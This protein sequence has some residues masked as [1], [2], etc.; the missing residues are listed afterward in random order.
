MVKKLKAQT[1][2]DSP[3]MWLVPSKFSGSF[4]WYFFSLI[5]NLLNFGIHNMNT[6]YYDAKKKLFVKFPIYAHIID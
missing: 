2:W 6:V 3:G 4:N 1:L 5:S